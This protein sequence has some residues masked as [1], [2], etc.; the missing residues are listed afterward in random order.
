MAKS[1]IPLGIDLETL[2]GWGW[3][4]PKGSAVGAGE[5]EQATGLGRR[6]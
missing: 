4:S 5:D 2:E 6:G 3:D 1:N